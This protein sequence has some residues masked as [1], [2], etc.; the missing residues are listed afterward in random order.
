MSDNKETKTTERYHFDATL[1]AIM[2][3]EKEYQ[4]IYDAGNYYTDSYDDAKQA[5]AEM[6]S[7]LKAVNNFD[8]MKKQLQEFVEAIESEQIIIQNNTDNDGW[9]NTGNRLYE[10][11][12]R[13][14][15][16]LKA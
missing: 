14:L 1:T 9:E 5:A 11:A 12:K 6:M 3:S 7:T 15:Q 4:T 16:T 13:I 2:D 8:L 10:Q